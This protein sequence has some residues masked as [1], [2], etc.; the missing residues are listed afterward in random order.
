MRK[1]VFRGRKAAEIEDD[2]LLVTVAE[3]GGH[4]ARIMHKQSGISPL[5]IPEWR[6][7]EPSEYSPEKNPEYGNSNEAKLLAGLFGHSV[8]LDLFGAPS[9][10][11]E[12]AGIPVH[13]EASVAPYRV[14]GDGT[15]LEMKAELPIAQ[16]RFTR[17]VEL[18]GQ[19]VLRFAETVEN[20]SGTDRPIGWTQH[21]TLGAPFLE[22]GQ[23]R[24]FLTAT[25]SRVIGAGFNQGLGMQLP[26]AD[27][28]W[29]MCPGRDGKADDL[30]TITSAA[31]SAGFTAHLM[32]P[33]REYASFAAWSPRH[34]LTIG[35]VWR[36]SDFPWLA[37]W[38]ENHL[39]SWAPWNGDGFA[40]GMEF[41]VSPMVEN[42]REMVE[43][44]T[45]F[46]IPA[47][48]WLDALSQHKVEY[49]AFVRSSNAL[50]TG[51]DWDGASSISLSFN[52]D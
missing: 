3:E 13:G 5:W 24:F 11:E 45:L 30:S 50:P 16:M 52:A 41:G 48:L 10:A 34:K 33:S 51:V 31:S 23:T 39:R 38:E 17:R 28:E 20:L 26:C 42:R 14:A 21:V 7:I 44:G 1:T 40:M 25:R 19:G 36:R 35:Y 6:S 46:G 37:R 12:K 8:C 49:C 15:W 27:F 9:H 32:D 2:D 18:V 47:F 22:A 43:R 4:I 29:P